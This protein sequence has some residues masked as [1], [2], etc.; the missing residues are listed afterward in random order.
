M[1]YARARVLTLVAGAV[2]T[3]AALVTGA[4]PTQ[5]AVAPWNWTIVTAAF[6][7][8]AT[9][10]ATGTAQCPADLVPIS[11]GVAPNGGLGNAYQIE[12][13]NEY[14]QDGMVSG[15]RW[16]VMVYNQNAGPVS[17]KVVLHCIPA[18][19]LPSVTYVITS[20]PVTIAG[21]YAEGSVSCPANT[22]AVA[23]GVDWD[24]FSSRT[25]NYS[26]P[27]L[28]D[29]GWYAVGYN[30]VA[31]AHLA[32]EAYCLDISDLP[33]LQLVQK[34]YHYPSG[35]SADVQETV[36]TCPTGTR[37]LSGGTQPHFWASSDYPAYTFGTWA[38]LDSWHVTTYGHVDAYV[39]L[40]AWC[41][42]A[43]NPSISIDVT[44]GPDGF[45]TTSQDAFFQMSG[46]DPGG[47]GVSFHCALDNAALVICPTARFYSPLADGQHTF[48]A[49]S[50]TQDNRSSNIASYS[51]SIDTTAPTVA[52]KALRRVTL[53]ATARQGWTGSDA[54]S[55]V[56][57]YA[58]RYR[59]AS[60]KTKLGAWQ[61]PATWAHLSS[62]AVSRTLAP[63][64]TVCFSVRAVDHLGN[65][66]G[67]SSQHCTA[68][69]LDDR[70]L[71][72]ATSGWKRLTGS[73]YWLRTA[74]QTTVH[75]ARLSR[76]GPAL[77]RVGIVAT[78]CSTCGVVAIFVGSVK[79]GTID[80]HRTKTLNRAVL[81]LPAFTARTG[82]VVIKVMSRAK[83]VTIDGLVVTK[84]V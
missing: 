68:R 83:R 39:Y 28:G 42:P 26:G 25:V 9:S 50:S 76:T 32:I 84:S 19:Q 14:A 20:V 71:T 7:A 17:L 6:T 61:E 77:D 51:W 54:I 37:V 58:V 40:R 73:A 60:Y 22:V 62:T 78:K 29:D 63:G 18:A 46:S 59:T 44:P 70:A 15:G 27:T 1:R 21:H 5:A 8:D 16:H 30:S 56:E 65:Q 81:L 82:K 31:T 35:S 74:T 12:M 48:T 11:G 49:F 34:E 53:G 52:L 24:N 33:G 43:G 36:A 55:G 72:R 75:G 41:V 47:A 67:W 57:S 4:P 79:I 64:D 69:P 45:Q 23:G 66:S 2:M 38:T 13:V 3:A 80:L 10:Y